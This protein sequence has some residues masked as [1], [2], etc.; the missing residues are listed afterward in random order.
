MY[1]RYPAPYMV[2]GSGEEFDYLLI[3]GLILG[4]MTV[5]YAWR[6]QFRDPGILDPYVSYSNV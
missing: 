5:Y 6:T 3:P 1:F 2:G 4:V